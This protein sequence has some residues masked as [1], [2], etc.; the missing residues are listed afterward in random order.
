MTAHGRRFFRRIV[1]LRELGWRRH[2]N[3]GTKKENT[4]MRGYPL[5]DVIEI[6]L[7]RRLIRAEWLGF[8]LLL[9][10]SYSGA[11]VGI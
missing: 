1:V 10:V 3:S 5:C 9:R 7:V 11:V 8:G 2:V 6:L 4:F